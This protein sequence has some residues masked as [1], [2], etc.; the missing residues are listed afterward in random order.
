[1]QTRKKNLFPV[2][3]ALENFVGLGVCVGYLQHRE[4]KVLGT[5][6]P[7]FTYELS[8]AHVFTVAIEVRGPPRPY[9][10]LTRGTAHIELA[11][12]PV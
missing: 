10:A 4:M 1:M 3:F 8:K 7:P 11:G 9:A 2:R 5:S 6:R 12:L